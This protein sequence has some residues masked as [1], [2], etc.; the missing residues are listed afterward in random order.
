MFTRKE[1]AVEADNAFQSA[2]ERADSIV[3]THW[4][5]PDL[6]DFEP[7]AAQKSPR[8][9]KKLA[10]ENAL[11]G[12][13][14]VKETEFSGAQQEIEETVGTCRNGFADD[15]RSRV[16]V[17]RNVLGT[18]DRRHLDEPEPGGAHLLLDTELT[19]ITQTVDNAWTHAS[20]EFATADREEMHA[21]R[22]LRDFEV[23]HGRE[24]AADYPDSK[25]L[26]WATILVAL[27]FEGAVNGVV[28]QQVM[29][30][31][32]MAV[33]LAVLF[34]AINI[35]A[36]FAFGW[37]GWRN[38]IHVSPVRK[39]IGWLSSAALLAAGI[40]WNLFVAHFR[41]VAETGDADAL[42]NVGGHLLADPL[43][44]RS[45]GGLALLAIGSFIF[46]YVAWKGYR[47][48]D[49]P[50]IGYG[51][52][53]RDHK[54][55]YDELV[56]RKKE[57]HT[58]IGDTAEQKREALR[59]RSERA[60]GDALAAEILLDYLIRHNAD[61]DRSVANSVSIANQRLTA[62]RDAN[63][64]IRGGR[65]PATFSRNL[66]AEDYPLDF[67]A[68]IAALQEQRAEIKAAADH[69]APVIQAIINRITQ[70]EKELHTQ[71]DERFA[72]VRRANEDGE[73][74]SAGMEDADGYAGDDDPSPGRTAPAGNPRLVASR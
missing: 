8:E 27:I 62:Y 68:D 60:K 42:A 12:L 11:E 31:F 14:D 15:M 33:G 54:D 40:Y 32:I 35:A 19:D 45:A 20:G 30:G 25:R 5:S 41:E 10:R 3:T 64:K 6:A 56:R 71:A 48:L 7:S 22:R 47:K 23:N 28:F 18:L 4:R 52:A 67:S 66:S 34:G 38:I 70:H 59:E 39:A 24:A 53:T 36:G 58:L 17:V 26:F 2:K 16:A 21:A 44:I 69:N 13:P 43:G 1:D 72:Q 74:R 55:A 37:V 63:M 29:D 61:L 65:A 49:D 46:L 9:L 50:Y 73:V 51:Q 57:V